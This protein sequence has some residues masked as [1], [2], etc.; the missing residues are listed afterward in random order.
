[1]SASAR[2]AARATLGRSPARSKALRKTAKLKGSGPPGGYGWVAAR[3]S[4]W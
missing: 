3:C 4:V 1:M 2:P